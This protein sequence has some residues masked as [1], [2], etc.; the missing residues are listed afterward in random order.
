VRIEPLR[1][2]RETPQAERPGQDAD[3][4]AGAET[5]LAGI[6]T[7]VLLLAL[8]QDFAALYKPEGLHSAHI[9]GN[10]GTSLESLL[11]ILWPELW[12]QWIGSRGQSLPLF[13]LS[14]ADGPVPAAA[15]AGLLS[16]PRLLTRLDKAT[17][18]IVLAAFHPEAEKR[19]RR[20]ERLGLVRKTYYALVRGFPAAPLLV[21]A[22][23]LADNRERTLALEEE[24]TDATRHTRVEPLGPVPPPGF[25]AGREK[26]SLVRVSI[27]RGVR[28]Q[29]RAHLAHAGFPV[30]GE[31]LYAPPLPGVSR[32]YLHHAEARMPGFTVACPPPWDLDP[33]LGAPPLPSAPLMAHARDGSGK[34]P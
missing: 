10:A 27:Q 23:L 25:L 22:R 26:C 34:L 12:E 6:A 24:E 28:H 31:W 5:A 15:N 11:S 18:G 2:P 19:F 29:I 14:Q 21:R 9:A 17:S 13:S 7:P 16:P 20:Q 33:S 8:N 30:F 4:P 32:L 1:N 3:A